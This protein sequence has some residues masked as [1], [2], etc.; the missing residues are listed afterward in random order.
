MEDSGGL[1]WALILTVAM[2]THA[3]LSND[4]NQAMN[5]QRRIAA[6][7]GAEF[8]AGLVPPDILSPL[9]DEIAPDQGAA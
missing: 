9:E 5:L 2:G 6:T 8:A 7:A 1:T 3:A 4:E